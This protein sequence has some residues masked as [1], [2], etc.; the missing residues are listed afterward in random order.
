MLGQCSAA[1]T[2]KEFEEPQRY[3]DE[4]KSTARMRNSVM[5]EGAF[6]QNGPERKMGHKRQGKTRGMVKQ[7]TLPN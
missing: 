5:L 3:N 6:R 7:E 2:K 1:E 4:K